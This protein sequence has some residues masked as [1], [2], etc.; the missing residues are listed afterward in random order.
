M[1]SILS[2]ELSIVFISYYFIFIENKYGVDS[3]NQN[4]ETEMANANST[5]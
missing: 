5:G 1:P 3:V 4:L 2:G